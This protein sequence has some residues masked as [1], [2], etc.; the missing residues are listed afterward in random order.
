MKSHVL[1]PCAA[2]STGTCQFLT[3][4]NHPQGKKVLEATSQHADLANEEQG[5]QQ[6]FIFDRMELKETLTEQMSEMKSTKQKGYKCEK[7]K[8]ITRFYPE[9]CKNEGSPCSLSI[10]Y[11]LPSASAT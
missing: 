4:F 1:A 8:K 7:C 6:D 2:H 10:L 3:P 5:R 9:N 11:H